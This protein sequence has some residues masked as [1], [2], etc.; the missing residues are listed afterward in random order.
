MKV[1]S[2]IAGE[3]ECC[4]RKTSERDQHVLINGFDSREIMIVLRVQ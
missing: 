2:W 4:F 3:A 1:F